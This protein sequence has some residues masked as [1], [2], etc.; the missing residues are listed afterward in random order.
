MALLD[1]GSFFIIIRPQTPTVTPINFA[2]GGDILLQAFSGGAGWCVRRGI[3][4][5]HRS[6]VPVRRRFGPCRIEVLKGDAHRKLASSLE[7]GAA[8]D[9]AHPG[10]QALL[11]YWSGAEKGAAAGGCS[12]DVTD[13]IST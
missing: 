2:G 6:G 5:C 3:I 8:P 11:C 10:F 12:G 7:P 4:R 13:L 9:G 1:H